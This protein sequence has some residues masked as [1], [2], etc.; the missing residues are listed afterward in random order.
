MADSRIPKVLEGHSRCDEDGCNS[1][2]TSLTI[3]I[4]CWLVLGA[5]AAALVVWRILRP[6]RSNETAGEKRKEIRR[7]QIEY[8][9]SEHDPNRQND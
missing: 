9:P 6:S 3:E 8:G 2:D 7:I 1:G 5:F 4:Y